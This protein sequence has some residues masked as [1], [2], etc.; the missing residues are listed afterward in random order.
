MRHEARPRPSCG[1]G[2]AVAISEIAGDEMS[3]PRR[4]QP[5]RFQCPLGCEFTS[6]ELMAA[7]PDLVWSSGTDQP[8]DA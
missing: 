5:V 4:G 1:S 7:L 2:A 3:A 8:T 6:S